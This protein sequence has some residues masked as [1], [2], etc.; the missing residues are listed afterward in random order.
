M[1]RT[2]HA[3]CHYYRQ[4]L[5]GDE[6]GWRSVNHKRHSTGDYKNPP[7]HAEHAGLR[8]WIRSHQAHT[9]V[10]LS[11]AEYPVVGSAFI[12]KL[13]QIG[14]RVRC[15]ACGPT[16]IHLLYDSMAADAK[17]EVG[18]AK[19][20]ASLKLTTRPGRVFARDCSITKSR[21][22]RT[23]GACGHTSSTMDERKVR[24]R[25]DMTETNLPRSRSSDA[26][27]TNVRRTF[28][29]A[30]AASDDARREASE[31]DAGHTQSIAS[32]GTPQH[33]PLDRFRA[34]GDSLSSTDSLRLEPV[35]ESGGGRQLDTRS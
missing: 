10:T 15:L 33:S 34:V 16:H 12:L 1:A 25:I 27:A 22:W 19:Q 4:W 24:G 13:D 17:E 31:E 2:I 6:R 3:I 5:P 32:L 7:P 21:T 28:H 35:A 9:P 11:P 8:N 20:F 18:R 26:S 14:G 29:N 23:R 30:E